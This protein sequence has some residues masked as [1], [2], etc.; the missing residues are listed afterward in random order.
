MFILLSPMIREVQRYALQSLFSN[1]YNPFLSI[2]FLIKLPYM[3]IPLLT[4]QFAKTLIYFPLIN[5]GGG[6]PWS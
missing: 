2:T 4:F 5:A 1:K 6:I 3:Y